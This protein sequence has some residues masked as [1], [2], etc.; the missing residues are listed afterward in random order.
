MANKN[1]LER[2]G[3]RH[4]SKRAAETGLVTRPRAAARSKQA[5]AFATPREESF[6]RGSLRELRGTSCASRNGI[7]CGYSDSSRGAASGNNDRLST[8]WREVISLAGVARSISRAWLY[9][10]FGC[11]DRHAHH[12]R[13]T[14][15]FTT[16]PVGQGSGLGLGQVQRL[17][18]R[19][20]AL[21][22]SSPRSARNSGANDDAACIETGRR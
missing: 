15:N 8:P 4:S 21:L 16:K 18:K 22:K 3:A 5:R 17:S 14:S 9:R 10:D 20:A 12:G 19:A 13:S 2:V 6:S 11:R 7:D 1:E